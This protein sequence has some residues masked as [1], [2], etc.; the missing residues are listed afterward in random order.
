MEPLDTTIA[1]LFTFGCRIIEATPKVYT[2][3][4][5]NSISDLQQL[6]PQFPL[7]NRVKP[8]KEMQAALKVINDSMSKSQHI[9]TTLKN[10][11]KIIQKEWFRLSSTE[12]A[13][14]LDVEDY[15]DFFEDISPNVLKYVVNMNDANVSVYSNRS[16]NESL[17]IEQLNFLFKSIFQ[18]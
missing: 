12:T 14:P 8:S 11:N 6:Q 18:G 16:S 2:Q 5:S 13:E 1:H 4:N 15:L 3:T 9:A 10:A 17:S 7:Q